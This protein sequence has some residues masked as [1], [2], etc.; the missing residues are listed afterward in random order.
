MFRNLIDRLF[1][2]SVD[3]IVARLAKT[4]TKLEKLAAAHTAAQSAKAAQADTLLV[5]ALEH[6]YEAVRAQRVAGKIA[7]LVQ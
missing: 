4:I 6:G 1:V 7:A 2:Q 5:E 3:R